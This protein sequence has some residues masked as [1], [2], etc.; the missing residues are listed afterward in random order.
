[1]Y[2]SPTPT[3]TTWWTSF[4]YNDTNR[5]RCQ[6]YI[7]TRP[8]TPENL[9][10]TNPILVKSC[11]NFIVEFAGDYLNQDSTT[12]AVTDSYIH[13]TQAA[14]TAPSSV[15]TISLATAGSTDGQIDYNLKTVGGVTTKQIR[16]Y[17][18]PRS[19][20]GNASINA[21]N[22]DVV[23]LRDYWPAAYGY[24]APFEV[25]EPTT[26]ASSD[27][28]GTVTSGNAMTVVSGNNPRYICA[29]GPKDP[30]PKMIRITMIVD[31]PQGRLGDGQT[32]EYIFTLP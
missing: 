21:A 16:W 28:T 27:Y 14:I 11:T 5:F 15:G 18:M 4:F 8:I 22:G 10:L 24:K 7:S 17:G 1:M 6:P 23:P 3:H 31:D 9:G 25:Y 30:K 2:P 12:G 20:T 32:Y 13:L 29:W 26:T 19:T